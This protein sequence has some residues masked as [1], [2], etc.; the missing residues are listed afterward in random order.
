MNDLAVRDVSESLSYHLAMAVMV[1]G[2]ITHEADWTVFEEGGHLL[3]NGALRP[4]IFREPLK[5][6]IYIL[7]F[8]NL[9]SKMF[10]RAQLL[11]GII[12]EIVL[13]EKALKGSLGKSR[14]SA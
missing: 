5:E 1:V 10:G 2:F 11:I 9:V 13:L 14:L 7:I 8:H 4:Q 12:D 6:L 3:Q